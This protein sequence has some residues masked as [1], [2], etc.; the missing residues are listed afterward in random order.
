MEGIAAARARG[1]YKGRRPTVDA[2]EVRRL[3]GDE[4]WILWR[5]PTA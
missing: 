2:A 3:N 1:I 4:K 5:A